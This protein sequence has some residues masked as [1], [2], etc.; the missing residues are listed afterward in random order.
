MCCRK[1]EN[2]HYHNPLDNEVVQI[3]RTL[4]TYAT[5]NKQWN[6][7]DSSFSLLGTNY[8]YKSYNGGLMTGPNMQWGYFLQC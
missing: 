6:K 7:Y 5:A 1:E 3:H 2:N 4:S 8:N